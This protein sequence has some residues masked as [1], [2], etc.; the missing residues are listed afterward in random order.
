MIR[1]N[2]G[3]PPDGF[4]LRARG[5]RQRFT[6]ARRT[7]TGISAAKF[8]A[9]VRQELRADASEL[10]RRFLFKCAYCE[11]RMGHVSYAHIEHYRPKGQ[12]R[13]ENLMFDWANWLNSCGICN[14]EKWTEFPERDG[15]P[16]LLDPTVDV[17]RNHISFR[18][19]FILALSDR[20]DATIRLVGLWRH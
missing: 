9:S 2:K 14:D 15:K 6:V 4:E 7:Q 18:S 10:A 12:R 8:W 16:L 19:N 20:V 13:F 17:P 1:V 5:L 3:Q 11:S